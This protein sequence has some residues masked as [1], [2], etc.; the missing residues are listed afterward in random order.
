[1]SGL[2][3]LSALAADAALTQSQVQAI[4]L[5]VQIEILQQQL[6]VGDLLAA[7][8]LPAQD[9][10]DRLSLLGVTVP[11]SLPPARYR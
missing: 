3:P 10:T 6:T 8:I 7:T 1:M 4:D 5:G 2:D 9:G 11:A